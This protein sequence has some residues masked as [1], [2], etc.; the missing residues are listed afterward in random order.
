MEV[1]QEST[2]NKDLKHK[3]KLSHIPSLQNDSSKLRNKSGYDQNSKIPQ[4]IK[5]GQIIRREGSVNSFQSN[6]DLL[7]TSNASKF[8][9]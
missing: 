6:Q 7:N 1:A 3:R 8:N 2:N 4:I 5:S 9:S